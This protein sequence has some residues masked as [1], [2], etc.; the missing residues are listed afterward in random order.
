MMRRP[1]HLEDVVNGEL[2]GQYAE[3]G[4]SDNGLPI[5]PGCLDWHYSQQ[6]DLP[7]CIIRR[8]PKDVLKSLKRMYRGKIPDRALERSVILAEEGL[9]HIEA[10]ATNLM[11]VDFYDLNDL[12]IIDEMARHLLDRPINMERASFLRMMNVQMQEPYYSMKITDAAQA[13]IKSLVGD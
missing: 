10:R 11:Q 7:V 1:P 9:R 12:D 5:F 4:D 2:F 3:V 6:P 8:D 13:H